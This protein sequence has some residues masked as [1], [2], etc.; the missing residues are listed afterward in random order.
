MR[1]EKEK[2]LAGELYHA[3]DPELQAE[4]AATHARLARYNAA[5]AGSAHRTARAVAGAARQGRRWCGDPAAV[6]LRLRLQ[7]QTWHRRL[8]ST[9]IV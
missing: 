9:S 5:L 8:F 4:L 3:G 6:L 2:M 1:T 7:Y